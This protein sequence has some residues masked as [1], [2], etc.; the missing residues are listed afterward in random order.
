[1]GV[2]GKHPI[3]EWVLEQDCGFFLSALFGKLDKLVGSTS[4]YAH[5]LTDFGIG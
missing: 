3:A 4:R 5:P 1:M 2:F